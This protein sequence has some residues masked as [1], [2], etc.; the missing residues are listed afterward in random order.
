MAKRFSD[1]QGSIPNAKRNRTGDAS[2]LVQD[3][4][5]EPHQSEVGTETPSWPH[6]ASGDTSQLDVWKLLDPPHDQC[7]EEE[8]AEP[9]IDGDVAQYLSALTH[10]VAGAI[11]QDLRAHWSARGEEGAAV[12]R[13]LKQLRLLLFRKAKH[14]VD[15]ELWIPGAAQPGEQQHV[16]TV[17]S[18]MVVLRRATA[19]ILQQVNGTGS[20]QIAEGNREPTQ[21]LMRTAQK[22]RDRLRYA[23]TLRRSQQVGRRRFSA[24]EQAELA[25]LAD[26]SLLTQA[27]DAT[28]RS[29]FGRIKNEDGTYE[30][31]APH[32]G[33]IV[34]T[35]LDHVEPNPEDEID[36]SE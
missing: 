30:D 20:T 31:I 7:Q 28:R 13:E 24:Q 25:L 6:T 22:A 9:R 10:G 27:N 23:E 18:E 19:H 4:G 26:G 5:D 1:H 15:K 8:H 35:I 32:G 34:R 21:D 33:G 14:P 17:V 12:Q 11:E 3:R 2:Q 29:G 16:E 36:W